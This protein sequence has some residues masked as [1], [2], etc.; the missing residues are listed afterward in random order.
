MR[1]SIGTIALAALLSLPAMAQN[2]ATSTS[3]APAKEHRMKS[4]GSDRFADLPNLSEDQKARL[5]A[6]HED[7]R[8]ANEPKREEMKAIRAKMKEVRMSENPD[9]AELNSL[10]D[11]SHGVKAEMEK[12]RLAGEMK[13]MSILTPE[14]QTAYKAKMKE[15]GQKWEKGE[16]MEKRQHMEQHR[17]HR[18]SI[19]R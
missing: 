6:I 1:K 10:I 4:H 11:K 9:Q 15:R 3:E 12:T 17:E 2:R 19:D 8:K 14:Q 13:A 7:T 16:K 18:N 5:K